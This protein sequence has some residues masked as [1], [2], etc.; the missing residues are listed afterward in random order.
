[1]VLEL[2]ILLQAPPAGIDYG[3]QKGSGSKYE[4]V[5]KQRSTGADLYFALSV[6][7]K[8][9]KLMSGLPDFKG[10]FVQGPR[11]IRFLYIDI[12]AAAGQHTHWSRRLKIPLTGIRWEAIEQLATQPHS[13]LTTQVVGT[14]KDGGP[15]CA[16]VKPFAGWEV[17]ILS[18]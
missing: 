10:P 11:E 13:V 9:D 15:N 16:T 1:M 12:G 14:G 2:H 7:V 18:K 5:Q 3:L 4:T 6:E 8:G 17:K